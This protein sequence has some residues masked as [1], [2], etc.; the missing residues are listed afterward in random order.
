M[1]LQAS[2]PYS[3]PGPFVWLVLIFV[4]GT[5]GYGGWIAKMLSSVEEPI[6]V[7]TSD[8]PV[9][10]AGPV[11]VEAPRDR[12]VEVRH[13]DGTIELSSVP[14]TSLPQPSPYYTDP[15]Q[16]EAAPFDP[17]P[18]EDLAAVDEAGPIVLRPS[19]QEPT[20]APVPVAVDEPT[21]AG[22]E[23]TQAGSPVRT[24]SIDLADELREAV[25]S[26]VGDQPVKIT[27]SDGVC[28]ISG[29]VSSVADAQAVRAVVQRHPAVRVFQDELRVAGA[30]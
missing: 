13:P 24:V 6:E 26:I 2:Q 18:D 11:P 1:T 10:Q 14:M 25:R 29:E 9:S 20:L 7:A 16:P 23:R 4:G 8:Y 17:T 15:L 3:S 21:P 28:R 19:R 5:I 22:E 27:L 12:Y 30:R